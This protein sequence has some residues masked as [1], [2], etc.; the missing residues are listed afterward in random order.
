MRNEKEEKGTV[1]ILHQPQREKKLGSWDKIVYAHIE[2]PD[3]LQREG[4]GPQKKEKP[5][6]ATPAVEN[7]RGGR[8]TKEKKPGTAQT[9]KLKQ[10]GHHGWDWRRAP[11]RKNYTPA[12]FQKEGTTTLLKKNNQKEY[13][14]MGGTT[15]V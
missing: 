13:A 6:K 10:K 8:K 3:T 9:P 2:M 14:V 4:G 12:E 1:F 7:K 5:V 15:K 11:P